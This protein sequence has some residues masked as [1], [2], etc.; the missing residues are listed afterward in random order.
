MPLKMRH[1]F[2][3]GKELGA[4]ADHD[5]LDTCGKVECDRAAS[6][7]HRQEREEALDRDRGQDRW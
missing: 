3:C 1:C 6:D 4:Y 2:N 5:P 7:A